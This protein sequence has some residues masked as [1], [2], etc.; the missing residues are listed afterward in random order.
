MSCTAS[1]KGMEGF[2][3]VHSSPY[4]R[5]INNFWPHGYLLD[6]MSEVDAKMSITATHLLLIP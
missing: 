4:K 2:Y 1:W 3:S 5:D 6:E